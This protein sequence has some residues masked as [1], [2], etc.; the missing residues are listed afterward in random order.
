MKETGYDYGAQVIHKAKKDKV[1]D[2]LRGHE[3]FLGQWA[4]GK[5]QILQE[6]GM[7]QMHNKDERSWSE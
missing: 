2:V 6:F 7:N 3:R 1:H 4:L 5:V